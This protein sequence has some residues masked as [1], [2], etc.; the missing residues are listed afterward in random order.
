[1][2]IWQMTTTTITTTITTI[3]TTPH[4][5]GRIKNGRIKGHDRSNQIF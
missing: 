4:H 3:T 5:H 2:V 1:M